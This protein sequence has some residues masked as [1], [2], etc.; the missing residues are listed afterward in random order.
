MWTLSDL[1]SW[2]KINSLVEEH[3]TAVLTSRFENSTIFGVFVQKQFFWKFWKKTKQ[4]NKHKID[5]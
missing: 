5:A 4:N 1:A 2:D 3:Y